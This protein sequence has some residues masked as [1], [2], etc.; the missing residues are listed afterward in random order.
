MRRTPSRLPVVLA[1]LSI[2]VATA[3]TGCTVSGGSMTGTVPA[4][5]GSGATTTTVAVAPVHDA[6]EALAAT[7][8]SLALV[9]TPFATGSAILLADG[10]LVTNAHVVDPFD[11]VDLAFEGG[12]RH[13][14][15]PVA[16]IDLVADL[17]LLGPIKTSRPARTLDDPDDLRSRDPIYL[18]GFPG[19][20]EAG[21][22]KAEVQAGTMT[23][24]RYAGSWGLDYLQAHV[25][26]PEGQSGGAMVDQQGRIVGISALEAD[27]DVALSLSG[28]DAVKAL[29]RMRA[30][31]KTEWVPIPDSGSSI[32]HS[33]HVDGPDDIAVLYVSGEEGVDHLS[34][35]VK[36]PQPR[37]AVSDPGWYI[38]A[39]NAAA[40][41]AAQHGG[42]WSLT[43]EDVATLTPDGTGAVRADVERG[44]DKL[45][46]VGS[47]APGGAD[48]EVTTS[49]P[50][51]EVDPIPPEQHVAPGDDV[52]GTVDYL[53]A[54][55]AYAVDL[56]AGERVL[57][58]ASAPS[59][60]MAFVVA[61]PG[62]PWD[63][64]DEYDDD[65]GGL[66]GADAYTRF[67]AGAA[68]T[69]HVLVFAADASPTVYRL[70]VEPA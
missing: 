36:G 65:G 47:D 21:S 1:C 4:P 33:I 68:G 45:L 39:R 38:Q 15:V 26:I 6:G 53:D 63:Q 28:P 64:A 24:H 30:G 48:L 58:T 18:V 66:L 25:K 34:A 10:Y 69:Y 29:A 13:R 46:L 62:Q 41:A 5:A 22:P 16:G 57:L 31:Q 55:D 67:T 60:D 17:A 70:A 52:D 42:F 7:R 37:I 40:T 14:G 59:G 8:S 9:D 35:T 56:A 51:F 43:D 50:S 19:D 44:Y 23:R 2:V 3:V 11:T 12:E 27:K 61:A 54:I 20:Q 49:P 32:H